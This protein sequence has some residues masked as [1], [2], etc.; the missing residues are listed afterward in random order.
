MTK[1]AP[2]AA[3]AGVELE[4][5]QREEETHKRIA[6]LEKELQSKDRRIA[7]LENAVKQEKLARKTL[8]DDFQQQKACLDHALNQ[9]AEA[10]RRDGRQKD[11]HDA[12]DQMDSVKRNIDLF[13]LNN[14]S[15]TD[16]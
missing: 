16:G 2:A 4:M 15:L 1:T 10:R 12:F 6:K 11:K 9:L 3:D 7:E 5:T 8:E 14:L 13:G